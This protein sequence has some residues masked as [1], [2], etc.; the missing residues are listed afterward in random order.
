MT[1]QGPVF[2]STGKGAWGQA[3]CPA[4]M[5]M[6]GVQAGSDGTLTGIAGVRCKYPRSVDSPGVGAQT[7]IAGISLP[8]NA[9][10]TYDCPTGFAANGVTVGLNTNVDGLK[11]DC[12]RFADGTGQM[13]GPLLG[14]SGNYNTWSA[15]KRNYMTGIYTQLNGKR[16]GTLQPQY[17]DFTDAI[18]ATYTASG[19][20]DG[21]MGVGDPSTWK[22]QPGSG[23]CDSYMVTD[24]C[25]KFPSDP[26]CSC[27][28]SEMTC[29]NKF[30]QNCIKNNGYRTADMQRVTCPNVMN[31]VQYN[32][33]SPDAK[34]VAVNYEQSCAS[35]T[36]TNTSTD[37]N[38]ASSGSWTTIL[39]WAFIVLVV[40]A[41]LGGVAYFAF[42][43]SDQAE[44]DGA[45]APAARSASA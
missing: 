32:R 30:D 16:I 22:Y 4:G 31:C 9:N 19:I 3:M 15:P 25:Q 18:A 44:S 35:T 33:L 40:L 8:P 39:V 14:R 10:S 11:L 38:A 41:V 12:A 29:P 20:A 43:G 37:G 5:V 7:N 45:S 21:C 17:R 23:D 36:N 24:F 28:T 27:I 42:S 26:R 34:A 6:T 13:T 1:L 2:G